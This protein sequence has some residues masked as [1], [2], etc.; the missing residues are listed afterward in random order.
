MGDEFDG[1]GGFGDEQSNNEG[2]SEFGSEDGGGDDFGFG[3][4]FGQALAAAE[5][6]SQQDIS[7]KTETAKSEMSKLPRNTSFS[8]TNS[9]IIEAAAEARKRKISESAVAT[10]EKSG[11]MK[12]FTGGK[13][14]TKT[15]NM[16]KNWKEKWFILKGGKFTMQI[17]PANEEG[18]TTI[19][20]THALS[21]QKDDIDPTRFTL[22]TNSRSF[23]FTCR[24]EKDMNSWVDNLQLAKDNYLGSFSSVSGA[25]G[26]SSS[27]LF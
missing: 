14:K 21:F 6:E 27:L 4:D 24:T 10:G 1:F 20:L 25:R 18:A 19:D 15:L 9:D 7:E 13:S 3:D 5:L 8:P 2:S 23:F 12:V 22:V 11:M 16:K 26:S 17:G